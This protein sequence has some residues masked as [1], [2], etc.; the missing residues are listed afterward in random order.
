VLFH[1]LPTAIGVARIR[2]INENFIGLTRAEALQQFRDPERDISAPEQ[3]GILRSVDP[4]DVL[5]SGNSCSFESKGNLLYWDNNHLS[6]AGADFVSTV[7][8][9]CFRDIGSRAGK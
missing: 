7:I 1:D 9:G 2:G 3:R 8:D 6:P 4:K 5:C